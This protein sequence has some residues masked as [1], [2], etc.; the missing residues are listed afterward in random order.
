VFVLHLTK[1]T[2]L[3]T[4]MGFRRIGYGPLTAILET[5]EQNG[6]DPNVRRITRDT[7]WKGGVKVKQNLV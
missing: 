3:V 4:R 7:N 2:T 1:N 6:S 5:V